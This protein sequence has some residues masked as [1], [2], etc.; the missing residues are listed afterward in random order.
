ME[1]VISAIP[2]DNFEIE[3]EFSDGTH[4][5]ISMKERLFGPVFEPLK[6]PDFFARLSIDEF[7]VICWPNGADIAPD[8]LYEK[9]SKDKS[10]FENTDQNIVG[11][12]AMEKQNDY[13]KST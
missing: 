2:L 3:V 6:D 12:E 7:G 5:V 9:L 13:G 11:A 4:G 10:G 1:R 8:A